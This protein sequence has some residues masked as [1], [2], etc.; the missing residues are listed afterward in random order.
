MEHIFKCG[1][2]RTYTLTKACPR[3]GQETFLARP[4]KF[5][6]EEKYGELRRKI[7]KEEW[8]KKGWY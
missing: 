2:C 3:C 1:S 8:K 4:P 6:P 5:S 7:K